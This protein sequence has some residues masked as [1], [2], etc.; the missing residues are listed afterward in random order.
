MASTPMMEQY[1]RIKGQYPDAILFYRMGDFYEMFQEDAL[2]ASKI[3]DIALTSRNKQAEQP[4]P[5]CG[6]PFHAVES[7]VARL[8][9]AGHKVAICEQMEEASEAKGLV[10][11]DVVRVVTP[12]T[13]FSSSLLESKENQF[14]IAVLPAQKEIG[15]AV[16]DLTTGDFY[17]AEFSGEGAE[18]DLVAECFR[19][20]PREILLPDPQGRELPLLEI[21]SRELGAS[22]TSYPSWTAELSRARSILL[23]QLQALSLQGFGCE[24]HDPAIGAAGAL[25]HYLR[26]TQKSNLSHINRLV[27]RHTGRFMLL[28]LATQRHLELVSSSID[29]S[30]RGTLLSVLDLTKTA[31]GGRRL[32]HWILFPLLDLTEIGARHEAV[33]ELVEDFPRRREIRAHLDA[34]HDFERIV[35]RVNLGTV[36]SRELLALRN[37]LQVF[38]ELHRGLLPSRSRLLQG[39]HTRWDDCSDLHGLLTSALAEDPPLTLKEGG[40]I[41]E[42][43]HG[44]LDELRHIRQEGR[45]WIARIETTERARTGIST[46]KV[47]HN[48]VFGYYIEVTN[49]Y[50]DAVPADYIRKQTLVGAERF[51]TPELKEYEAKVLG[52]EE[53]A[54][55]LEYE[56]FQDLRRQVADS[57][58]RLQEMGGMIADLDVLASLAEVAHVRHYV[59]P[60]MTHGDSLEIRQGRHP[61][62]EAEG[63]DAQFIPNDSFLDPKS[64]QILLLTGP[65]MAGK[66]T[67]LR[68]V[69]LITLMAHMGSFVPAEEA[70]VPLVDRIFTRVGAQDYLIKGQSTFM[71]EMSEAANILHNATPKSLVILDEIGRG[72]STYDGLSIAWAMV[73]YLHNEEGRQAKTLFSTHYHELTELS[74]I[75]PRVRNFTFAVRE[76]KDQIVFLRRVIPGG[77]DRS[78]GIQVARLAGIPLPVIARAKEVLSGLEAGEGKKRRVSP[79]TTKGSRERQ[80]G[81]Q[82]SLFQSAGSSLLEEILNLDVDRLTPVEALNLLSQMKAKAQ[83]LRG[84]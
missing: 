67:Y 32:K 42:G 9:K 20:G 1:Y 21:S 35:S 16:I 71:V 25:I 73:E 81:E 39:M 62:V 66:S 37:S 59:R 28:D 10:T 23:Q 57:T 60:T 48:R 82:L 43:Y 36:N 44:E 47:R 11:R 80:D 5:M 3:L 45:G 19:L 52:A 31:I 70:I 63:T 51:I 55:A 14:I 83:E 26:E 72:T 53:R 74:S 8:I 64:Q 77:A 17:V 56:I 4:V 6:V 30:S 2:L 76:W 29:A 40:L 24:G 46:L 12:G 38:P 68:Q 61:V 69:A 49:K 22:L 58:R 13:Q 27:Y 79:I 15:I 75:F 78:Y 34:I 54:K 33:E 7:Y 84:K 50:R 18:K 65:N 41:R